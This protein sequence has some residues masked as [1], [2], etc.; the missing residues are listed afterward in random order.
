MTKRTF[1][2]HLCPLCDSVVVFSE[3]LRCSPDRSEHCRWVV[4]CPNDA[5]CDAPIGPCRPSRGEALNA[6][7]DGCIKTE[8]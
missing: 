3:I 2:H 5:H 7:R 1:R 4:F 8:T 6:F